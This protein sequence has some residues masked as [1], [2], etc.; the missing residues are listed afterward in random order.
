[1]GTLAISIASQSF[2]CGN[3]LR[4]VCA[5]FLLVG[6]AVLLSFALRLL[7]RRIPSWMPKPDL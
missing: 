5:A 1:M 4:N 6:G 3:E 2:A 7:L